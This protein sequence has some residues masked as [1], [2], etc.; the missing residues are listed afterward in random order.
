[1]A[2][3]LQKWVCAAEAMHH[4]HCCDGSWGLV[5]CLMFICICKDHTGAQSPPPVWESE[6]SSTQARRAVIC[7][8]RLSTC[9]NFCR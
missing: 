2:S 1:M 5:C 8:R 7:L 9:A 3:L 6:W 4:L